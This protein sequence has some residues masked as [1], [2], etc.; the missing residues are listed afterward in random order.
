MNK[1][2]S[3]KK[4]RDLDKIKSTNNEEKTKVKS[5]I[6]N[7]KATSKVLIHNGLIAAIYGFALLF[8][9]ILAVNISMIAIGYTVGSQGVV[10]IN[11]ISDMLSMYMSLIMVGGLVLFFTFKIENAIIA[12]AKKR[13]WH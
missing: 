12:A 1:N 6:A 8:V 3:L 2:A 11:T 5:V 13:M 4:E 7:T 9:A 10:A